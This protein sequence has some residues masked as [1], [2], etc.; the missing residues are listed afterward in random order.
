MLQTK[1]A[2]PIAPSRAQYELVVDRATR[3]PFCGCT[4]RMLRA[5]KPCPTLPT[6]WICSYCGTIGQIGVGHV[7]LRETAE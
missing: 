4:P 1:D 5:V 3:C 6:F 2:L 7:V